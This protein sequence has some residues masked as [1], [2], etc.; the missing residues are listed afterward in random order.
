MDSYEFDR[1]VVLCREDVEETCAYIRGDRSPV[2]CIRCQTEKGIFDTC[3]REKIDAS[4]RADFL[5]RRRQHRDLIRQ[6]E[7]VIIEQKRQLQMAQEMR[8]ALSRS[9]RWTEK[10]VSD[11]N[12]DVDARWQAHKASFEIDSYIG[13]D[14][15][16]SDR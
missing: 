5:E 12:K 2:A 3:E 11:L 1:L 14:Q 13:E 16:S 9:V 8:K 6:M 4:H 7:E 15:E 10:L